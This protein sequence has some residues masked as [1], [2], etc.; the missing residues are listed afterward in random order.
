MTARVGEVALFTADVEATRRF[1]ETLL[2][3][4][5]QAEWPGGVLF[6]ADATRLPVGPLRVPS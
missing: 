5:P 4:A 1:Y 2:R 3:I 6:V